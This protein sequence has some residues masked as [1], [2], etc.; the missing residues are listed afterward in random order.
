MPTIAHPK[1]ARKA[2]NTARKAPARPKKLKVELTAE[3]LA[4][5]NAISVAAARSLAQR[6]T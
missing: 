3:D 4:L 2:A 6:R 1:S 5:D